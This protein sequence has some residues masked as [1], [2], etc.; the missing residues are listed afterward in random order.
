MKEQGKAIDAIRKY[1]IKP[2]LTEE[3][4]FIYI[5]SLEYM[6][7]ETKDTDYMILP[8]KANSRRHLPTTWL[9][10]FTAIL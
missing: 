3:A 5:E 2:I 4:E 1:R 7:K 8:Q 6:I 10:I 9:N